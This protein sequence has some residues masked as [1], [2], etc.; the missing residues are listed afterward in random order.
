MGAAMEQFPGH[1]LVGWAHSEPQI[2]ILFVFGNRA[3]GRATVSSDL[4]LAVELMA[5]ENEQL[6]I[7]LDNRERWCADLQRVTG[8]RVKNPELRGTQSRS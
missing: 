6:L 1:V 7:F 2:R 4:D 3:T 8:M 5:P